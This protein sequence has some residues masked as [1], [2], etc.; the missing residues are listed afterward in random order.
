M[1]LRRRFPPPTA[2]HYIN[3]SISKYSAPNKAQ[4]KITK[5]NSNIESQKKQETIVCTTT[6]HTFSA[7]KY[8]FAMMRKLK[9][10]KQIK[11]TKAQKQISS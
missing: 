2:S 8:E 10:W 4:F 11:T 7:N 5:K 3:R 9:Q 1:I 6:K